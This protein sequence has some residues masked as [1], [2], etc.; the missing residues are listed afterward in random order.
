MRR[1]FCIAVVL[2]LLTAASASAQVSFKKDIAP[3]LLNNCLACHG[4]KKAEGAYRIDTYE[5]AIAPG[6]SATAAFLAKMVDG[7]EGFR[8]I[9]SGDVK[10]RM[11][12]DGDP[13]SAETIALIKKWIEEG[14]VFDGPDPKAPIASY[15]PPPTHPAAPM[16]YAATM[17]IT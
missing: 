14:A 6:E 5:R 12:L 17:P 16:A 10:E 3:V 2:L 9:T 4:P 8:R 13:L 15:I 7:S 11:P 1:L